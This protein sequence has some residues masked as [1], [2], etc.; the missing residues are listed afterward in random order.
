MDP[1]GTSASG[2]TPPYAPDPGTS[3]RLFGP[4]G[5]PLGAVILIALGVLLLLDNLGV[6]SFHWTAQFWPIVLIALG[7]WLAF[8][9]MG[10]TQGR[11]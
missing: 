4:G 3:P 8:R 7:L 5:A 9:R 6:L 10:M 11:N 1:A 2:S